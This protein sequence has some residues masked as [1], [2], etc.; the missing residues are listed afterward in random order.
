MTDSDLRPLRRRGAVAVIRRDAR[1][2]VIRRS[3]L[4]VAPRAY[5]FPGGGIEAGESDEEAV[6]REVLE[7]LAVDVRPVRKLWHSTTP[8][9]VEL[10]WWLADL[11][12]PAVPVPNP[13]EVESV[14]WLAIGEIRALPELLESNHHF[15]DAHE[16]GEFSLDG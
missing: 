1:L 5:C 6:C 12:E 4:V 9:Q 2:L 11:C 14:H 16:R 8:R 10:S 7:E 13:A 15:L 3:T